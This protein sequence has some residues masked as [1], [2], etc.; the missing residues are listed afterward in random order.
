MAGEQHPVVNPEITRHVYSLFFKTAVKAILLKLPA[1]S[2]AIFY[3]TDMKPDFQT[4]LSKATLVVQAAE[5]LDQELLLR[6]YQSGG[7]LQLAWHKVVVP[8]SVF[9]ADKASSTC[10]SGL[11]PGFTH[12][13]CVRKGDPPMS[14][15]NRLC[16]SWD[17]TLKGRAPGDGQNALSREVE[18]GE[19][20]DCARQ[21][22]RRKDLSDYD[23]ADRSF[24]LCARVFRR[25]P[26]AVVDASGSTSSGEALLFHTQRAWSQNVLP[27]FVPKG[28]KSATPQ[29]KNRA[30]C[31]GLECT[32]R[33][34][35]WIRDNFEFGG[36]VDPF[37]GAGTG[38]AVAETY[39]LWSVG[40]DL[41]RRRVRQAERLQLPPG[42]GG[43]E[44]V[45][46]GVVQPEPLHDQ[47]ADKEG[48]TSSHEGATANGGG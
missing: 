13:L 11:K 15:K 42:G 45:G 47:P 4:H 1:D 46:K 35:Q 18:G 21:I 9:A 27:A 3:Q 7:R 41:S 12:L 43:S 38:L 32:H 37:C 44:N 34:L 33:V 5:E 36:L 19:V 23:P 40:C 48:T 29:H 31:Q 14:R 22:I 8:E 26:E 30:R 24:A 2:L 25:A 10:T 17:A 6:E 20:K 39:G 16:G 28:S